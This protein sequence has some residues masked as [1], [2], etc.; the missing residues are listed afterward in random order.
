MSFYFLSLSCLKSEFILATFQ[1]ILL[2]SSSKV[3]ER[4]SGIYV[5]VEDRNILRSFFIG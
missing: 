5:F 2:P 1:E 4:V 3:Y